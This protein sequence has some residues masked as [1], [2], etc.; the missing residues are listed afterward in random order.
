MQKFLYKYKELIITPLLALLILT[1]AFLI[2]G[3]Y[4]FGQCTIAYYD[5]NINDIPTYIRTKDIFTGNASALYDWF[6]G[7]GHGTMNS[8]GGYIL[9]PFNLMVLFIPREYMAQGM[10]YML[11]GKLM[12]I[13]FIMAFYIRQRY[14]D[15]PITYKVMAALLYT[16]SGYV[17]QYYVNAYF[18]DAVAMMPLIMLSL[19]RLLKDGK[20]APYFICMT[21]M[22]VLSFYFGYMISLFIIVYTMAYMLFCTDRARVG[23]CAARLGVYTVLA[24]AAASVFMLPAIVQSSQ[25]SRMSSFDMTYLDIVKTGFCS[26]WGNKMMIFFGTEFGLIAVACMAI[27]IFS[28]KLNRKPFYNHLFKMVFLLIPFMYEGSNMLWHTGTYIHY[29][30]RFGFIFVFAALDAF[31]EYISVY[32][33]EYF[34]PD[35]KVPVGKILKFLAIPAAIGSCVLAFFFAK[36]FYY[37]GMHFK[38]GYL[39]LMLPFLA[40]NFTAFAILF[41]LKEGLFKRVLMLAVALV[42]I[43]FITWGFVAPKNY[44]NYISHDKFALEKAIYIGKNT[45]IEN[46]NLSRVRDLDGLLPW[47]FGMAA[48]LPSISHWSNETTQDYFNMADKMGIYSIDRAVRG[49]G[50]TALTDA[51]FNI[52]YVTTFGEYNPK[53]YSK[54]ESLDDL[55]VCNVKYTLPFGIPVSEEFVN[56]AFGDTDIDNQNIM[57]R[58]LTGKDEDIMINVMTD[59][60][61]KGV[62]RCDYDDTVNIAGIVDG[63][64]DEKEESAQHYDTEFEIP[65][66]GEGT[67]YVSMFSEDD[68]EEEDKESEQK[69]TDDDL[70]LLLG[71]EDEKV[72]GRYIFKVNG[73]E[74]TI[75]QYREENLKVYPLSSNAA[76][77]DLGTFKD[78]TVKLEIVTQY[79]NIDNL[80]IGLFNNDKLRELCDYYADKGAADVA[81][82]G[83]HLSMTTNYDEESYAYIPLEYEGNNWTATVN[84][85]KAEVVPALENGFMAVKVPAGEAKIEMTYFPVTMKVGG[86]I[87]AIGIILAVLFLWLER[88]NKA[89]TEIKVIRGICLGAFIIVGAGFI[90]FF[91]IIPIIFGIYSKM[92]YLF[93]YIDY[94]SSDNKAAFFTK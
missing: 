79:E 19:D 30:M 13:S 36:Q 4:P 47:N 10:S 77:I 83:R 63:V 26:F 27:V 31:Y 92:E 82:K 61:M 41:I 3:I 40:A 49:T 24:L 12:V 21:I 9:S 2:K 53:L 6:L 44:T 18:L 25:T 39:N 94:Q 34:I 84:G 57:Y 86:V 69:D 70:Q 65:V 72:N 91:N 58:A 7:C 50:S 28:K 45:S 90:I 32:R 78:E 93:W 20:S 22:F 11:A 42:Q 51:L 8:M 29:P 62:F 46:D 14:N 87:S 23:R 88:K 1:I 80:E 43:G 35:L 33:D 66:K 55:N 64:G 85:E 54:K 17:V 16:F 48:G 59:E 71:E 38:E 67:L 89:V 74:K 56:L 75:L 5:M 76:F 81:A 52:K 37:A 60:Y 73:E 68:E 15:I